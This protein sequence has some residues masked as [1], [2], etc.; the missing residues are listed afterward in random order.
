MAT[1]R[2][3]FDRLVTAAESVYGV[4][5][6]RQIAQMVLSV[7]A[8]VSLTDLVVRGD[9]GV[10]IEDME[11]ILVELSAARPV[12]YIL[13]VAEFCGADFTVGEGVLIPRPETEEL[14]SKVAVS[15]PTSLLDI[16]TG[17]GCIA[18]SLARLLP[19]ADVWAVDISD[20]ALRYAA[21]NVKRTGVDIH[22]MKADA[23]SLPDFGVKF[24]AVVS[25]PP[26][27][28]RS[29]REAM[30]RNVTEYEPSL[31]LFVEDD[32]PLL[33]YRRIA[34]QARGMLNAE[35]R[36]W[37]EIHENFAEEVQHMLLCEDYTDV[38]IFND[39]NDKARIV[40]GRVW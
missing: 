17:S 10:V 13:G 1:R 38:E 4:Q 18:V 7:R 19:K 35:G 37:F 14:V 5:E 12:Q 11:Q 3:I 23:L 33:F 20:D 26:Y 22:L 2:E 27:I 32:D 31:A 9:E 15:S 16:G 24:D 40:C 28:P 8:G 30:R 21:M 34:Q 6:A 29:E 36:V 39:I 25:N